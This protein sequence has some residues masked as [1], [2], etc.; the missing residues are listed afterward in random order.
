MKR[1]LIEDIYEKY[2]NWRKDSD[3]VKNIDRES[4]YTYYINKSMDRTYYSDSRQPMAGDYIN[5]FTPILQDSNKLIDLCTNKADFV[6]DYMRS[7]LAGFKFYDMFK[8][9]IE[10]R[11]L[12]I[13]IVDKDYFLLF[14]EKPEDFDQ[15]YEA[16]YNK[17]TYDKKVE[18]SADD[19]KAEL[20]REM[21]N[22]RI[23]ERL[24]QRHLDGFSFKQLME[25]FIDPFNLNKKALMEQGEYH[26]HEEFAKAVYH[27]INRIKD[28]EKNEALKEW[29][30]LSDEDK[31]FIES[32]ILKYKSYKLGTTYGDECI[33]QIN[34]F[35]KFK[36]LNILEAYTFKLTSN[37]DWWKE[38]SILANV[39]AIWYA[40]TKGQVPKYVA[41]KFGKFKPLLNLYGYNWSKIKSLII[42]DPDVMAA[43][44]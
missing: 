18:K 38:K 11:K 5:V 21:F 42:K 19:K 27:H 44:N 40:C 41:N 13:D 26:Y 24:E 2:M 29:E 22:G 15:L 43:F 10:F 14:L 32:M 20:I 8:Y 28:P 30:S 36:S 7:C 17:I 4:F 35:K 25:I 16:M 6:K 33:D 12:M 31:Q 1:Y 39:F 34:Y 37:T 3:E 23:S 9:P